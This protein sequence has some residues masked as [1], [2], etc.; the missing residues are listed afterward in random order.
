MY[1]T[2]CG[3]KI[4]KSNKFCNFCGSQLV[5]KQ[6]NIQENFDIFTT[7]SVREKM[8]RINRKTYAVGIILAYVGV[9]IVGFVMGFIHALIFGDMSE[10][11]SSVYSLILIVLMVIYG[12]KLTALRLHDLGKSGWFMLLSYIPLVGIVVGFYILLGEGEKGKNIYGNP[13][14]P[15]LA[16]KETFRW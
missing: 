6:S 2:Q 7:E 1:C 14:S 4:S 8:N 9:I 10:D 16:L 3:K 12:I 11:T 15:Q 5:Q 13:P